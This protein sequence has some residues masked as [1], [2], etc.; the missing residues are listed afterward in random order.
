MP[1]VVPALPPGQVTV[2]PEPQPVTVHADAEQLTVHDAVSAQSTLAL[3]AVPAMT[4][5]GW[6]ASHSTLHVSLAA[7]V[8]SHA[9]P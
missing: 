2:Q 1:F 7:H 8:T 5:H 4:L 3:V 6:P 9:V